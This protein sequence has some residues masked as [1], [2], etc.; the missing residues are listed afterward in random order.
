MNY[1]KMNELDRIRSDIEQEKQM[2]FTFL[3]LY[4]RINRI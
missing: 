1:Y 4:N 2:K 3:L